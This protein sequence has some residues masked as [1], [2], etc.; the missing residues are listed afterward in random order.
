M[1]VTVIIPVYN[2]VNTL[3]QYWRKFTK[4]VVASEILIV[5]DALTD[6]TEGSIRESGWKKPCPGYSPQ[7]QYWGKGAA[8]RTGIQSATVMY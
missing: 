6:G 5:D 2:E 3:E 7:K 1:N 4:L 8:V